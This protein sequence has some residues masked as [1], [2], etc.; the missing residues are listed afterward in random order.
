MLIGSFGVFAVV[1][2]ALFATFWGSHGTAMDFDSLSRWFSWAMGLLACTV[3]IL[4]SYLFGAPP[5]KEEER[6]NA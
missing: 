3:S 5:G 1:V 2:L 4:S 6:K